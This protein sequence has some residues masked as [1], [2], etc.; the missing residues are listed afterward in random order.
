MIERG[1][2]L[3]GNDVDLLGLTLPEIK[4]R[5]YEGSESRLDDC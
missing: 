1:L 2:I 4:A 5:V 3:T